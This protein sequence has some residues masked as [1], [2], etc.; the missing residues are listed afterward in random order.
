MK[1]YTLK[2]TEE[3]LDIIV[4]ML[5][6]CCRSNQI[7]ANDPKHPLDGLHMVERTAKE[8]NIAKEII[9][10]IGRECL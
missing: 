9:Q 7:L 1:E 8:R 3:E 4:S 6:M 2:F 5:D 10:K